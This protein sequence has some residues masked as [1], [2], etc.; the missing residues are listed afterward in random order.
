M[1]RSEWVLVAAYIYTAAM[2]ALLPVSGR[3]TASVIL[4]NLTVLASYPLLAY[5]HSLRGNSLLG[6]M[7]D[8]YP[9]PLAL[10]IYREMGW[11][12]QPHAGRELESSWVVWDRAILRGGLQAAIESLGPV[13]PS[14]LEI[15]YAVVYTLGL[16]VMAMLYV[17]HRR[18][19]ADRLLF[20]FLLSV[21]F[22]YLQFPFWPSEPPRTVFPGEDF[23]QYDTIFRRFNWWLLAG[24]GIH[25]S[26]FP[27]AHVSGAF[28]A[29]FG[30]I[31]AL[32]EK[33]WLGRGLVI[34]AV[35]IAIA[36]VYGRYHYAVDALAGFAMALAA[37]AVARMGA[38]RPR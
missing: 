15:C 20:V 18:E 38:C 19:R 8:W 37:L 29:A 34:T 1:R 12:A 6:I 13:L 21:F 10:L 23:P 24:H 31:R 32:P 27:S 2:S 5:A 14:L 28:G 4:L 7:R 9:F 17:Y 16:F 11:F 25:T 26:V 30:A 33:P 3:V 36:T 35:L 22:S